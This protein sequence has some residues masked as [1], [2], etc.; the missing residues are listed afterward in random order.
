MGEEKDEL[1]QPEIQQIE[2]PKGRP[3]Q[4]WL[5]YPKDIDELQWKRIMCWNGI[6]GE[7]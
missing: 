6:D 5:E 1:S 4:R 2:W 7:V 3:D